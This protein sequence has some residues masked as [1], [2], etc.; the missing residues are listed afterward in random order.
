MRSHF[1]P[2]PWDPT[3]CNTPGSSVHGIL[4][5]RTLE[6][7]TISFSRGSSQ[8]RDRT[9][10]PCLLHWRAGSL[11]LAPTWRSLGHRYSKC[12]R[13]S[14][15]WCCCAWERNMRSSQ[16]LSALDGSLLNTRH[17]KLIKIALS[18]LY[19][20]CA[21]QVKFSPSYFQENKILV[22]LLQFRAIRCDCYMKTL[23]MTVY[24]YNQQFQFTWP[25][26]RERT[27]GDGC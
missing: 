13:T 25:K 21:T 16:H 2:T 22:T 4:Q 5:A 10:V 12:V 19:A 7:V 18:G 11:P 14:W 9:C 27:R 17:R 20:V 8:P 24:M 26:E 6:C 1:S 15:P 3:G 23:S